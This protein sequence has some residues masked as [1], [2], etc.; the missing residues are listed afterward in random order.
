MPLLIII[1]VVDLSVVVG[2]IPCVQLISS[3]VIHSGMPILALSYNAPNSDSNAADITFITIV[4]ETKTVP[5]GWAAVLVLFP[6]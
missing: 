5:L 1:Y 2:V 3:S 4:E 6:M